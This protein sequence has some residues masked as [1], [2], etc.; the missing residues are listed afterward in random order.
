[1]ALL[2]VRLVIVFL[3]GACLG[4][5]VNWA[6]YTLAW[7][8]RPISPWCRQPEGAGPR[9]WVDRA[10]IFGWFALSREAEFHGARFWWRPMLLELAV[11]IALAALYWWEVDRLGLIRDQVQGVAVAPPAWPIH[12]QYLSHVIL[13]CWMMAASFID[14]DEKLIPDEIT[15]TGTLLGLLLATLVPM[16]L[17]PHVADRAGPPG[18]GAA[19]PCS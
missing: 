7:N 5:F 11:G 1:M 18:N 15:V 16:S 10:P 14:I 4:S 3:A 17:L 9:R 8:P 12:W 13:F 19:Q 6:I 2:G